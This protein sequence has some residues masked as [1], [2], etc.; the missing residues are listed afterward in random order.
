MRAEKTIVVGRMGADLYDMIPVEERLGPSAH[1]DFRP[2]L[3]RDDWGAYHEALLNGVHAD[4]AQ[5]QA[6][7]GQGALNSAMRGRILGYETH[8]LSVVGQDETSRLLLERAEELGIGTEHVHVSS[9]F[10]VPAGVVRR[11]QAGSREI[12]VRQSSPLGVGLN[13]ARIEDAVQDFGIVAINSARSMWVASTVARHAPD[14]AF[15]ALTPSRAD[16]PGEVEELLNRRPFDLVAVNEDELHNFFGY[17]RPDLR[18]PRQLSEFVSD[19]FGLVVQ[20]TLG[21]CGSVLAQ[22]GDSSVHG[23]VG[24]GSAVDESGAGDAAFMYAVDGVMRRL[25]AE[26]ILQRGAQGACEVV[27]HIGAHGDCAPRPLGEVA[28]TGVI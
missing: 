2:G 8:L 17:M 4:R 15:L 14:G 6:H 24:D 13:P 22:D 5:Y 25:P 7:G 12:T 23:I 20:C 19:K 1:T 26:T 18:S 10:R 9:D 27:G 28:L 16:S 21:P 3:K 11:N